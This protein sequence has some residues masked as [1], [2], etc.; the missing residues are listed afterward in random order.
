MAC[1]SLASASRTVWVSVDYRLGPE[2]KFSTQLT[3]YRSS[4]EW[5][6]ANR[7]Q[8]GVSADA[9]LGVC[10]D[11][12]GGHISALLTHEYKPQISFQILIYPCV[13]LTIQLPSNDEFS[14]ECH[15]LVPELLD[16]FGNNYL[17]SKDIAATELVSPLTRKDFSNMPECLIVL[18][19]L[20]PLID[21]CL[22]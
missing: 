16:Y 13:H 18:A 6:A 15:F 10:G 20:D 9:K 8:F 12:A 4:F 1:A 14:S 19:E 11:S 3:D 22:E 5:I 21:Q 2:N 7:A 17:E